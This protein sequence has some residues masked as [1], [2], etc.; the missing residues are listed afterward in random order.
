MLVF[1]KMLGMYLMD[2]RLRK[3]YVI[4]CFYDYSVTFPFQF[5]TQFQFYPLI[6]KSLLF[7]YSIINYKH[8]LT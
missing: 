1:R 5:Y 7:L 2:D 8:M 4:V 6:V 3:R